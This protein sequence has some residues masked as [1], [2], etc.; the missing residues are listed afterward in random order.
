MKSLSWVDKYKPK[1]INDIIGNKNEITKIY[2]WLNVYTKKTKPDK[3]WK[4]GLLISGPPGIGK[5]SLAHIILKDLGYNTIEFNASELRTSKVINEKINTILSGKSVQMMFNKNIKTAIILDEIDGMESKKEISSTDISDYINYNYNKKLALYKKN[6]KKYT[7]PKIEECINSNPIICICNTVTKSINALIKNVLHI[8]FNSPT[9]YDLLELL[10]KI[11]KF[12]NLNIN[13]IVLN[14]IVP[15]CQNDLRRTIYILEYLSTFIRKKEKISN[16][17]VIDIINNIGHKDMDIG[18]YQAIKN[19]FFVYDNTIDTLINSYNADTNFVPFII[20]ENFIN[21]IDK[22]TNCSYSEK[23]DVCIKYY[24]YLTDSQIFKNQI[25][26]QWFINDYIGFLSCYF[27]NLLIKKTKLK[28]TPTDTNIQKSA[29]I[30]KY[31]YRYYNLKSINFLSKKLCIDLNNFQI[32][33]GLLL[34]ALF[35]SR[36][37][38]ENYIDF[39]NKKKITFKEFEKILKL[40][41]GFEKYQKKWTKKYQKELISKFTEN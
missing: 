17:D 4:N 39:F 16:K 31:N 28:N 24:D 30:S 32:F 10:K 34:D 5:T 40:T 23:L 33:A 8:K 35:N 36:K 14:L 15:H 21:F 25:F 19:V 27:P 9:D 37:T 3:N 22:N 20:H 12:E 7:K 38:I 13:E 41:P 11:N 29:L 26:G 6:K 18:L 1:N 2:K